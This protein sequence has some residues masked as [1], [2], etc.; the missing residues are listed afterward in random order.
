MKNLFCFLIVS[1]CAHVGSAQYSQYFMPPVDEGLVM[2]AKE[3]YA[4]TTAGD[5]VAGRINSAVMMGGQIRSLTIKKAD[6][7]KVKLKA[8][9][10][11]LLAV[12]ATD[13][14]N[15]TSAMSAPN[16][17]RVADMDYQK[18]MKREWILF[19]QARLP[20]KDK[21]A[22]MQ[23]LNPDFCSK[24]K[25]YV[26]PNANE[27]MTSSLNGVMLAGGEDTSYLVVTDGDQAE[28]YKKRKYKNEALTR[29]FKNC[30]TFK[31]E[32]AGEKFKWKDFSEHVLVYDQLCN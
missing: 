30:E 13:F 25:V 11:K 16:I 28:I 27:T 8:A 4:I 24:I 2:T 23:L 9:D 20:K 26:N 22:L 31:E 14:M 3:V 1:L 6:K 29:L 17:A 15:W 32:Y 19:D 12:K 21:Y 7:S 5:S 10:V 18:I